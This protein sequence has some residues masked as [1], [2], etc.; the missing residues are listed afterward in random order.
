MLVS[1]SRLHLM[2]AVA[3]A[4]PPPSDVWHRLADMPVPVHGMVGMHV[5]SRGWIHVIGGATEPAIG[6][7]A[8]LHQVYHPGELWCLPPDGVPG[9]RSNASQTRL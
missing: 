7:M 1:Q 2:S 6:G 4:V 9:A 3:R 8:R 5:D